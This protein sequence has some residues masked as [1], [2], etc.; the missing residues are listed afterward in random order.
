MS[1]EELREITNMH[2]EK[3]RTE[4][5]LKMYQRIGTVEECRD[6]VE[7]QIPFTLETTKLTVGIGRCKCGAEFL[8]S[9]TKFCGNCGQK[10]NRK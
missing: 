4:H 9:T 8:D 5:M 3:C 7:K 10:L 6:A 2:T 1:V